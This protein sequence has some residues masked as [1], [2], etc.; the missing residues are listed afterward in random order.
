M[1]MKTNVHVSATNISLVGVRMSV[2]AGYIAY[3]ISMNLPDL[4]AISIANTTA[5]FM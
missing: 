1:T 5:N 2:C 4:A 3:L